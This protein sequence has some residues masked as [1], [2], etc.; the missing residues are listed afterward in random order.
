[1]LNSIILMG[2]ITHSLELKKTPSDKSVLNFSIAVERSFGKEKVTDFFDC[3]AWNTTAEFICK[4]FAKGDMIA[5]VGQM[6]TRDYTGK[7]GTKKKAYEVLIS[8]ASFCG[9]KKDI[10]TSDT[11]TESNAGTEIPNVE[12]FVKFEEDLPF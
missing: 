9:G 8:Q 11:A 12:E 2:R 6:T 5:V 4:Y 10:A 3:V 1:M 7:D